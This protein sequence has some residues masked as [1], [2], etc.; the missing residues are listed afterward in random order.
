[1]VHYF[2]ILLGPKTASTVAACS[3]S[4]SHGY[5]CSVSTVTTEEICVL[6]SVLFPS[7][8]GQGWSILFGEDFGPPLF[9]M[10]F[11]QF[12]RFGHIKFLLAI[13][14]DTH[15]MLR[16]VAIY[17]C[18]TRRIHIRLIACDTGLDDI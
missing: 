13:N 15:N 2:L 4:L 12:I 8:W 6:C 14:T 9:A 10:F 1:M 5:A 17:A 18:L 3:S 7:V 16:D 11:T